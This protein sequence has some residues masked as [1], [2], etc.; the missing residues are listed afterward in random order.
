MGVA[1]ASVADGP[2]VDTWDADRREANPVGMAGLLARNGSGPG[3]AKSHPSSS[4]RKALSV[5]RGFPA[6]EVIPGEAARELVPEI[7][8]VPC[9]C[10]CRDVEEA[11]AGVGG[12]L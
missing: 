3:L 5:N 7:G 12:I 6:T 11:I 9:W 2:G 4:L 10:S 8:P 1:K